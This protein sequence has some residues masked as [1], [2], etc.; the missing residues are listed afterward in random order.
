M[1]KKKTIYYKD[2]LNDEFSKAKI[3]PRKIDE[4][5]VYIH[6]NPFWNITSYILQNI[7]SMPIKILYSK[8][9]FRIKYVGKEKLKK[10]KKEGYF[11][12]V[13]HTQAFAD[14]FLPSIANYPKRNFF[15]VNPEN[16]SIKFLG[17]SV[18]MLGAIPIPAN[19][20]AMSNFLKAVK[21]RVDKGYSVT[22]Y[23]EA[24]IWPYY[25]KIR[26]FRSV[27]FKYPIQFSKPAFCMTNTYQSYG[28]DNNKIRIIT[29]IDGPFFPNK[30]I[31][32]KDQKQDLRNRIYECM[33]KR[34][35]NSNI[36]YIKYEK[37]M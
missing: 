10:Y 1:N 6:K 9:K 26:N 15:I 11:I 21:N 7:L 36:E 32:L 29:Y 22:I 16:V 20:K 30:N 31:P 13:N 23:P 14:T 28:K 5:Y 18:Q 25:T 12:Y 4:N 8:I 27:S 34:S 24:H 2:E 37:A 33:V 19:K 35:E 17:N 3:T